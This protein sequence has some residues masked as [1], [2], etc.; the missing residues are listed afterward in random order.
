MTTCLL[1]HEHVNLTSCLYKNYTHFKTTFTMLGQ[2]MGQIHALFI[3]LRQG[4]Q[5]QLF[6]QPKK[7]TNWYKMIIAQLM[8]IL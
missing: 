7:I 3:K 5:T 2:L 6:F 8:I 1:T 4:N